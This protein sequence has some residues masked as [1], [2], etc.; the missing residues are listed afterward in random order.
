MKMRILSRLIAMIGLLMGSRGTGDSL[1][2]ESL[3]T[4][5]VPIRQ[6]TAIQ[7]AIPIVSP[8]SVT[9]TPEM[10][11]YE[12]A[13]QRYDNPKYAIRAAAEQRANQRRAR[14][15]AMEWYGYSNSRPLWGIDPV[16]GTLNPQWIGNGYDPFNWVGPSYATVIWNIPGVASGF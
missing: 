14:M 13:L 11:F 10:W 3:P 4:P 1:A 6:A 7:P 8:G 15:A 16:H 12:Q 9:A 2:D 5:P